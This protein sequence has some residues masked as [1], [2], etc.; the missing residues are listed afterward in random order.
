MH[1]RSTVRDQL[2]A[3]GELSQ[4]NVWQLFITTV[5]ML[6]SASNVYVDLRVSARLPSFSF[7]FFFFFFFLGGGGGWAQ[8]ARCRFSCSKVLQ[9]C[10]GCVLEVSNKIDIGSVPRGSNVSSSSKA[11]RKTFGTVFQSC[12]LEVPELFSGISRAP[13]SGIF[14]AAS[15]NAMS[16]KYYFLQ[17]RLGLS[18]CW[19][20]NQYGRL[21]GVVGEFLFERGCL[22][23]DEMVV[24]FPH[25]FGDSCAHQSRFWRR[26]A[27]QRCFSAARAKSAALMRLSAVP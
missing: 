20:T 24:A 15:G 8:R 5:A 16:L 10:L 2:W 25:R 11:W 18:L 26:F 3:A 12:S 9:K 1:F 23:G 27:N 6:A 13:F 17:S 22:A 14:G 4:A 21:L 7:L 19:G